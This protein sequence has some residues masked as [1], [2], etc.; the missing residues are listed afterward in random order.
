MFQKKI[1][2]ITK[3]I[4]KNKDKNKKNDINRLSVER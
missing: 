4:K 3:Q 1:N 2:K